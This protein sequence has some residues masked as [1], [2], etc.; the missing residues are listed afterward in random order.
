MTPLLTLENVTR[1]FDLPSG[2]AL[3][4]LEEVSVSFEA[5]AT[6]AIIGPS[7]S[8]KSTLLNLIGALDQPTSGRILLRDIDVTALG[9]ADLAAYRAAH[10]GFVFQ[11]HHLLPQLSAIENVLLPTMA[12]GAGGDASGRTEAILE[13]VGLSDRLDAFPAQLSGGERQRVALARALVNAPELLLCDEPTGNLDHDTGAEV[14]SLLLDLAA[15]Q[16]VTVLMVTHNL[17]QAQRFGQRWELRE[18]KLISLPAR[19][20]QG[21][22][23]PK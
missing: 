2:A 12:L 1:R 3:T 16:G 23:E 13:Q 19:G 18:G 22:G 15:Q 21:G 5:G 20:G 11:E 7:G 6:A 8:G 4:V 17:E 9:A 10:V 14:V